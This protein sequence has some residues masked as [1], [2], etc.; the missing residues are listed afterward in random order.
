VDIAGKCNRCIL[1]Y[2]K[3]RIVYSYD[4]VCNFWWI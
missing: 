2:K 1:L 4:I 3:I